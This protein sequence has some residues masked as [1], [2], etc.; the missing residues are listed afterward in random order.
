MQFRAMMTKLNSRDG[1]IAGFL[2]SMT[3]IRI[4]LETFLSYWPH[5]G[6]AA[7]LLTLMQLPPPF[8]AFTSRDAHDDLG[9]GDDAR[10]I[11]P[12]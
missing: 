7:A 9:A 5:D 11:F 10:Q 2:I 12:G 1:D 3:L 8:S 4:L 6:R